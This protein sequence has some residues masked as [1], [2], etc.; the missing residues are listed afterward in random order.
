[1]PGPFTSNLLTDWRRHRALGK[2]T[3]NPG[4][5]NLDRLADLYN[6]YYQ[7]MFQETAP[8][9]ERRRHLGEVE[10]IANCGHPTITNTDFTRQSAQLYMVQT[11]Q[12]AT[13][14]ENSPAVTLMDI[15]H[16]DEHTK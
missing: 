10:G 2:E 7:A 8:N 4:V 1:M 12:N 9:P 6:V 15:L 13:D 5:L 11:A 3:V 14:W 16:E